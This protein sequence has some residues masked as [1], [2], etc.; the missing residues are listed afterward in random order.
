MKSYSVCFSVSYFTGHNTLYMHPRHNGK[1]SFFLWLIFHYMYY[2]VYHYLFIFNGYLGCFHS[3]AIVN[4]AATN[5]GACVSFQISIFVFF[6]YILISGI[7][8]S[9]GS[10]HFSFLRNLHT[11][12]HAGCTNLHFHQQC[13]EIPFSYPHQYLLFV[14]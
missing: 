1:V 12:F 7:D 9:Y 8:G 13:T 6:G 2:Y 11:V 10:S 14:V 5:I 4:N 3:L